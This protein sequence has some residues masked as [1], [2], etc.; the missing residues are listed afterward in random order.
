MMLVELTTVPQ[1]ALPVAEFRD[2]LRLGTG[3]A[4]DAVQ[5]AVLEA[6]LRAAMASIEARTGKILLER[7]FAWTLTGW[8]DP[9]RQ[10]LPLAPVHELLR[11][12]RIDANG[13]ETD[14]PTDSYRL[15][16]D[17][18]RPLLLA[19]GG[20]L[21]SI[22]QAGSIRVEMRAGYGASF[23]LV[24]ADLRQAVLILTSHF[25]ENRSGAEKSAMPPE[26]A[27]LIERYKT[28]RL[29]LGRG[30]V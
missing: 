2:H 26:V 14:L 1:A 20:C 8:R 16:R 17:T 27:A 9:D 12:V 28:V 19:S 11:L 29:M 21:P 7:D 22:P 15:E 5:D 25:Y 10:P 13:T 23:D 18:H 3:F 24:P 6:Y 30:G 4:D